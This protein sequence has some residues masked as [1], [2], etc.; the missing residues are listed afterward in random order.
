[1]LKISLKPRFSKPITIYALAYTRLISTISKY[2]GAFTVD[3]Y[4]KQ[5]KMS[6]VE[7]SLYRPTCGPGLEILWAESTKNIMGLLILV[8][9]TSSLPVKTANAPQMGKAPISTLTI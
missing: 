9:G 6:G 7:N 1:M 3:C 5:T 8:V 4:A 2:F